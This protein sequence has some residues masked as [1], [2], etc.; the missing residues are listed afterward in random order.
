MSLE[1]VRILVITGAVAVSVAAYRRFNGAAPS[2]GEAGAEREAQALGLLP[3]SRQNTMLAAPDPGLERALAAAAARG[4]WQPAARL[5]AAT[6]E[7]RDWSRRSRY[8]GFLGEAAAEGDGAWLE[9]WEAALP[10]DPDAAVVRASSTVCLAWLMR[11]G[12]WAKNTSAERFAGFFEVLPRSR[13]QVARAA[14]LAPEDP[15]PYIVEISTAL[16]LNYPHKKM[17]RIWKEITDR[18]PHHPGAHRSALQYW[19]AKWHGSEELAVRFARVAADSAPPG[20]LLRTL[21]LLAWWEHR[22][23]EAKARDYRAPELVALVDAALADA[24]AAPPDHPDLPG[25]RHLLAYFLARQGRFDAALE[26]FRLVDGYVGAW[27]WAD[28]TDP[29]AYYCRW[30]DK[31]VRGARGR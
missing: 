16:G 3:A 24:A 21:P 28:Y 17:H 22:G 4:D 5:M 9:A 20:S 12:D 15:T 18:A 26:Q 29:V 7:G 25:T 1:L 30:R 13:D 8:A 14:E 23:R 10:D 27:P 19:C 2:R 11:G 6:R 31:A